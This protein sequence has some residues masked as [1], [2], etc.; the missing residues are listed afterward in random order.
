MAPSWAAC[1]ARTT[2]DAVGQ[3]KRDGDCTTQFARWQGCSIPVPRVLQES[4]WPTMNFAIK[5]FKELG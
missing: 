3:E 5:I 1:E 4:T 2:L